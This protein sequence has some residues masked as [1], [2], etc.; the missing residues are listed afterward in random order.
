MVMDVLAIER[1]GAVGLRIKL[2]IG[3]KKMMVEM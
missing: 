2:L 1:H 3:G